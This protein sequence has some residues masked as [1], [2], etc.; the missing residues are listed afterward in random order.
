MDF[1]ANNVTLTE[2]ADRL[3]H[4]ATAFCATGTVRHKGVFFCVNPV[5]AEMHLSA[6]GLAENEH[7]LNLRAQSE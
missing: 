7:I 2:R 4:L 3:E 1:A 6:H 5:S